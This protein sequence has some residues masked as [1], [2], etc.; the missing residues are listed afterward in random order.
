[1]KKINQLYLKFKGP[2]LYSGGSISKAV[3]QSIV[4]FV[5]VKYVTPEDFGLWSTINLALTYSLFIQAGLINGLNREL[6]FLYGKGR[7]QEAN[8][9][10]GTVQT[11]TLYSSLL[12]LLL[13]GSFLLI[14]TPQNSKYSYGIVAIT[15]LIS[16]NYYQNYLSST[17]R[18]RDSFISLSKLQ[19][20]HAITNLLTLVF[21]FYLAYYGLILKAIVVSIVYVGFMHL[22]RPVRVGLLWN[23]KDFIKL[24]KVGFPI[25]SLAFIEN[26]ASTTDKILLLKYSDMEQLG[27]YAFGYYAFTS[28]SIFPS[29]I[30]SYIYPNMSFI[31]GKSNNKLIIW[32]YSKKITVLLL[33]IL[34]PIAI[35]GALLCP[36]IIEKYF[37]NY[38]SSATIMQVLIIAGVFSGSVISV[39]SLWSL[40][41]WKYMVQYQIGFSLLLIF[42]PIIGIKIF[43]SKIMGA[44]IGVLVAHI[45]NLFSG[46][47]FI[48][49]A[50]HDD[51]TFINFRRRK[52]INRNL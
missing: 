22:S 37:P 45:I 9:M 23:K 10:A 7:V 40:K 29:S 27:F 47:M 16:L 38:I 2:I 35:F 17:Y 11:F 30:A 31:Y 50:T 36:I 42:C 49:L 8:K 21:V 25:F 26:I 5:V 44:S 32:N 13:G 24:L 33:I 41:S 3:A 19:L 39:N 28:F 48:Y 15:I 1:L 46:I 6:P 12:V 51:F 20:I 52:R 14:T 4:G 18:S 34:T 43:E